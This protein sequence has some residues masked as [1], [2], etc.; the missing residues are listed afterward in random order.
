M[1]RLIRYL[2]PT[3]E[4]LRHLAGVPAYN[5]SK[6]KN[7]N[8]KKSNGSN[9]RD[10]PFKVPK[11]LC[12]QLEAAKVKPVD[13]VPLHFYID[14][15]WLV[16]F[17]ACAVI[18]YILTEIYFYVVPS[19]NEEVNLSIM[20][21]LLVIGI[22]LKNLYSLTALYFK[23]NES[24][25]ERSMS[26]TCGF[27]FFVLAMVVLVVD[28]DILEFGLNKA[29]ESFNESITLFLQSQGIDSKNPASIF[30]FKLTLALWCG[31]IGAFFTFPGI[32][33]AKMHYD[34]LKYSAESP[35]W[36]VIFNTSFI[37]PF[38]ISLLWVKP[39]GRHYFTERTWPG[40]KSAMMTVETFETT[41]LVSIIVVVMWRVALMPSY[42]Q[43]YLNMAH[44]RIDEMKKE[45]GHI[46]SLELQKKVSRVFY[47]LCV[48]ALQYIAPVII[49][50]FFTFLL[51]TL[52]AYSW[53]SYFSDKCSDPTTLAS[54]PYM[55]ST[56]HNETA[57][58][59]AASQHFSLVFSNMR[60]IFT[61]VM[62]RGV[63]N[64][65]TWWLCSVWFATSAI[66]LVYHSYFAS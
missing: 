50:I 66:G 16:D 42:L 40:M 21:C 39:I 52:G 44:S 62:Y 4:E 37:A 53:N 3:T 56:I 36:K 7:K 24:S 25:G 32:R 47:Y 45:V 13:V 34:C 65:L 8:H 35:I 23:G 31:L 15:Q 61:P 9:K 6:S 1:N 27:L 17:S 29:Y 14:Y 51:K 2:H 20:W 41:R 28:E 26:L 46:N 38:L 63:L 19:K 12:I 33:F 18:V 49:C 48:V 54:S 55:T 58:I 43:S 60:T 22:A 30:G 59:M 57:S 5:F 10:G 11:G 64:F